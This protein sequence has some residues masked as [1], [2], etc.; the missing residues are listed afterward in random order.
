MSHVLAQIKGVK[1]EDIKKALKADATTHDRHGLTL[2]HVWQ[3]A[4]D[5]DDVRFLFES[6][7]LEHAKKFIAEVHADALKNDPN[8][9]LPQMTFLA[10]EDDPEFEFELPEL[11]GEEKKGEEKSEEGASAESAQS[12]FSI[13]NI[14][15]AIGG[16]AIG[17]TIGATVSYTAPNSCPAPIVAQESALV[18]EKD[19]VA[20][21]KEA[22][23]GGGAA[24]LP[25][26]T[27]D[28]PVEP[29]GSDIPA[30]TPSDA[31][32][33]PQSD[34]VPIESTST[35]AAGEDVAGAR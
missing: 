14:S 32:T 21:P 1:V 25:A 6:S 34:G 16:F 9:K 17:A 3:N 35:E 7:D 18:A 31:G 5:A 8:V 19:V 11:E 23:Y 30:E 12:N 13:K 10:G 24:T 29:A 4:D 27:A 22:S 28:T 2:E 33:A 20:A 26:E 15:F